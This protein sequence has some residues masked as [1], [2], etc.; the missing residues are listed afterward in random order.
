ME[1]LTEKQNGEYILPYD[2]ENLLSVSTSSNT[3]MFNDFKWE[4]TPRVTYI[5]G[6]FVNKLGEL[7]DVLEKYVIENLGDYIEKLNQ[8]IYDK[9]TALFRTEKEAKSQQFFL[10][11]KVKKL[12][13]ELT[14][15][16]R[17][18]IVP[19]FQVGQTLFRIDFGS[20]VPF[21]VNEIYGHIKADKSIDINYF[22]YVGLIIEEN[23]LFAT[24]E[25]AEQK[26]TQLKGEE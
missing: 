15:L 17:K 25:E 18:A 22:D 5:E 21:L 26:L 13:Q 3:V 6:N 23:D 9:D 12:E 19:K 24:R 8:A 1:R 10:E 14:E 16:K 20:I 2:G 11:E 4:T 7:E